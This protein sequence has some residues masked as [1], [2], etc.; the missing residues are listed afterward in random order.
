MN[1]TGIERIELG[2]IGGADTITVGDLTGSGVKQVAINLAGL[3]GAGDGAVDNVIASATAGDDHVSFSTSGSLITVNGLPEQLTVDHAEAADVLTIQAGAGNDTIDA[4]ALSNVTLMFNGGAGNDTLAFN[5]S[6]A[7]DVIA[8]STFN[9]ALVATHGASAVTVELADVENIAISGGDG[10]DIITAVNVL[11]SA[12]LTLDGGAGNDTIT[13]GA[14]ADTLIGGSG[15]DTVIGGQGNDV[16]T[17]G[18]GDDTF[19]WNPGDG[20]DVVDGGSGFDTLRFNASSVAEHIDI[21]ANG[22]Q[23]VLTRDVS[24]VTMNLTSIERIELGTIG[25][26]DTVNVG[27]LTGSGVKQV[28]INLAGLDGAGDG[29]IDNVIASATAGNDHISFGVSGSLITVNGLPEQL[30]VD[31]A[32]AADALT[33]QAGAGNDTIDAS[34]LSNVTLMLN[35]GTGNDTF[36][37]AF[38]SGGHDVIQDFQVHGNNTQGDVIQLKGFSDDFAHMVQEGHIAQSGTDVVITDGT[39]TVVTLQNVSLAALHATDFH[40]V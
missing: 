33:I 25:G 2:T 32:E 40:F 35:G 9:G 18:N 8:L 16:A 15:N 22:G 4:S 34:A 6:N 31:H 23:A 24:V 17:L 1:L 27:D 11:T 38:G 14:G 13:G 26:A 5:G 36:V 10:N 37:F 29:A 3:D 30:T 19:I 7:D 21:V 28:A 20:S 39:H 12:H